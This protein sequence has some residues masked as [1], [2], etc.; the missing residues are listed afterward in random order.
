V[1]DFNIIT[2]L[3]EKIGG[4][5]LLEKDFER[6]KDI[7][8]DLDLVDWETSNGTFT[9]N[10]HEARQHHIASCLARFLLLE[11]LLLRNFTIE[12]T[13]LSYHGLDH[14]LIPLFVDIQVAP[15]NHPFNI[16]SFWLT[17]PSFLSNFPS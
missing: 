4:L 8:G 15:K 1:G 5:N 12:A 2:S 3:S 7:I 16:K 10:N 17:N 13:I 11:S 9:W 6:S 14:W